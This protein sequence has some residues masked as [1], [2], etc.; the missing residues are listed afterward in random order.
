MPHLHV[1][2][3][4]S[5]RIDRLPALRD[6]VWR[7]EGETLARLWRTLGA[8][9]VDAASNRGERLLRLGGPWLRKHQHVLVNL[10]TAFPHWSRREVE[11]MAPRVWGTLGR[12]LAEY[13]CL[14]RICDPAS[15]RVRVVDLGGIDHV[16]RSGR[17]AIYVA[18]H[19]ANWNLLPVAASRSGIQL[20]V[21]FRRQS[22]PVIEALMSSWQAALGCGF[23]EVGEASRGLLRELRA[24]RSVGLLMDQ[25]YD[26]GGEKVPFFGVPANTTLVPARLAL[27]LGVPLIPARIE[28]RDGAR[29]LITVHRPIAP[30][31]GLTPEAAARDMTA[32]VNALFA[33][34][35][36]A[37]PDQ[38]L[39]V[40]R[41]W[42][43]PRQPLPWKAGEVAAA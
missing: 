12:V 2:S 43:R 7:F 22:N 36:A 28:R 17:P 30:E 31:A 34:W 16:R 29:F 13:A 4:L 26:G 18:P 6:R 8:G 25:R 1:L 38:W 40:K 20:T 15:D 5:R 35:I 10:Q 23:V 9:D 3:S 42:P 39:C 37:A 11:A 41:R 14:D 33:R 21:V 19:L 27:R 24:G 32:Q